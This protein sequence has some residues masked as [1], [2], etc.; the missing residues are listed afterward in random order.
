VS[1]VQGL[2]AC[3]QERKEFWAIFLLLGWQENFFL[4]VCTHIHLG[5]WL[6][7]RQLEQKRNRMHFR[8]SVP[9]ALKLSVNVN[10]N[11]LWNGVLSI[12]SRTKLGILGRLKRAIT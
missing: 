10:S 11:Q 5:N 6:G 2:W 7:N 9:F 4:G 1:T 8:T 3:F 12:S